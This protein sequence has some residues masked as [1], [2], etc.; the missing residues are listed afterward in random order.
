VQPSEEEQ[1]FIIQAFRRVDENNEAW[2]TG[3]ITCKIE[4]EKLKEGIYIP[5]ASKEDGSQG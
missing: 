1:G 4:C 2:C 5:P 3:N